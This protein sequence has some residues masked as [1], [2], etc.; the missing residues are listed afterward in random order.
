MRRRFWLRFTD[1]FSLPKELVSGS[2]PDSLY[3]LISRA[4]AQFEKEYWARRLPMERDLVK[5]IEP[6][7]RAREQKMQ[8]ELFRKFSTLGQPPVAQNP[9][10]A[11]KPADKPGTP[12]T[13]NAPV[14]PAPTVQAKQDTKPADKETPT[15]AMEQPMTPA[16]MR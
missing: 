13:T 12:A 1:A 5:Q 9:P 6:I 4:R 7:V 15:N 11:N 8:E 14:K 16:P 3:V 2:R 10:P